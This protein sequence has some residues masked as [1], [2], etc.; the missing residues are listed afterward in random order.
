MKY[1]FEAMDKVD[2]NHYE[3]AMKLLRKSKRECDILLISDNFI[4]KIK[5]A[6]EKCDPNNP[7]AVLIK[8]SLY[9]N[10]I[11]GRI[12]FLK[13]CIRIHPNEV[14]FYYD[15]CWLYGFARMYADSVKAI[16]KA[17][18]LD[19]SKVLCKG[20]LVKICNNSQYKSFSNE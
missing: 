11:N 1:L 2:E 5:Y 18:E 9:G 8:D 16:D 15:L 20:E 12:N 13:R 4:D 19:Q 10:D 17:F 3:L 6:L 14:E 7:D